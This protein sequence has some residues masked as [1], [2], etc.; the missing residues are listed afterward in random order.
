MLIRVSLTAALCCCVV[1][2]DSSTHL[3]KVTEVTHHYDEPKQKLVDVMKHLVSKTVAAAST[4]NGNPPVAAASNAD[5]KSSPQVELPKGLTKRVQDSEEGSKPKRKLMDMINAFRAEICA[6]LKD[7]HGRKFDSYAKCKDFMKEVC[8][9]GKDKVMDGD[10]KEVTS[11]KGYCEEYFSAEDA[12][13]KL[14]EIEEKE[15]KEAAAIAAKEKEVIVPAPAPAPAEVP[16]PAP[17]PKTEATTA[18]PPA[19]APAP[20]EKAEAPAPAPAAA[21]PA[22]PAA[23]AA[24]LPGDEEWYFK[25]EGK[26]PGRMHMDEHFKLPTQGY[27][28]KLVGHD[29]MKT[30]TGD[31]RSEFGPDGNHKS[32]ASI[33]KDYPENEWCK[34]NGF[35]KKSASVRQSTHLVAIVVAIALSFFSSA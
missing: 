26:W 9:P 8:N 27:W 19:P 1:G 29:D 14:K 20:E 21:A 12:E 22:G 11:G 7:E 30:A 24:P 18:A 31:W 5:A 10:S 4:S 6:Q 17:A 2:A 33:C 32:Y 28:G 3:R 35:H 25:D 13:K 34:R 15:K 16:A 23:P